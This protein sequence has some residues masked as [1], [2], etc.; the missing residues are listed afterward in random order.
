MKYCEKCGAAMEDRTAFCQ[1]CGA[2]VAPAAPRNAYPNPTAGNEARPVGYLPAY[3]AQPQNGVQPPA[4]AYRPPVPQPVYAPA[5]AQQPAAQPS[6]L[7]KPAGAAPMLTFIALFMTFVNLVLQFIPHQVSEKVGMPIIASLYNL[8]L[9]IKASDGDWSEF[10][11]DADFGTT[12]HIVYLALLIGLGLTLIS[13]LILFLPYATK[14][15]PGFGTFVPLIV[16]SVLSLVA[17]I[18]FFV[19]GLQQTEEGSFYA[20]EWIGLFVY[21]GFAVI[22]IVYFF[23]AAAKA[24]KERKA[25]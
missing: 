17:H 4:P 1:N 11:S 12:L 3:G 19:T 7:A 20:E 9:S 23:I 21:F 6:P 10:V 13:A 16:S 15:K 8:S 2:P 14:S 22:A 25:G 5:Y 24:G 18:V